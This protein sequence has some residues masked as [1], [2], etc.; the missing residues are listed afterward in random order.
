MSAVYDPRAKDYGG[1]MRITVRAKPNAKEA[2]LARGSSGGFTVSVGEP[3]REG[4]A[5]YAI[6]A[7][8]AEYFGVAKKPRAYCRGPFLAE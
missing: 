3:A 5:N 1:R 6:V 4:K 2:R 8:I 7:A